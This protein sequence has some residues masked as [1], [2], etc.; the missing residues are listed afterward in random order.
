MESRGI[1]QHKLERAVQRMLKVHRERDDQ[2]VPSAVAEKEERYRRT[3]RRHIKK[4]KGWL[5]E[6]DDKI[7]QSGKPIKSNLTDNE[8]AKMTKS[9]GAILNSFSWP[10]G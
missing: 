7:G 8:S 3:L 2:A 4:L 9:P 5:S 10:A 1:P 6:N